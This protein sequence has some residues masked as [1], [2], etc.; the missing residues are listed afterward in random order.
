MP[1]VIRRADRQD[2]AL[3]SSLNADVQAVHA[4]AMPWLF[5][6]PGPD[7]F[8]RSDTAEIVERNDAFLFVAEIDDVAAGYVYAEIIR[9]PQ[10]PFH[11][12][13]DAVHVHHISVRPA[14]R[15]TGVGGALLAAVR[16]AASAK[17][18]ALLS[19]DV[20]TFNDAARAFFR[21][22]GF[23][24]CSERLSTGEEAIRSN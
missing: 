11:F 16:S 9:R 19:A 18:V 4:S 2:A 14:H 1:V 17:G 13:N 20:W 10:T 22:N 24:A 6:P 21:R 7:A 23:L 8:S 5:K 15:R 3:L 12:A